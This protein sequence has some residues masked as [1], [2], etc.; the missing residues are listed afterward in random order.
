MSSSGIVEV[1]DREQHCFYRARLINVRAAVQVQFRHRPTLLQPR[2][3]ANGRK[4][5][6]PT[7]A[8]TAAVTTAAVLRSAVNA[9]DAAAARRPAPLVAAT[10]SW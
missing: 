9:G 2:Y 8:L 10:T 3:D 4:L 1:Q 7:T 5:G 6:W